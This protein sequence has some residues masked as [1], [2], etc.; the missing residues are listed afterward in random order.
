MIMPFP[1]MPQ[2]DGRHGDGREHSHKGQDHEQVHDLSR[3]F[4]LR[5][6]QRKVRT[7][8][9]GRTSHSA[10]CKLPYTAFSPVSSVRMRMASSTS[11]TKILPSPILPVL[12]EL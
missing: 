4:A 2:D 6:E 11:R 12:A 7:V 9:G 5:R 8:I 3:N 1:M 10:L